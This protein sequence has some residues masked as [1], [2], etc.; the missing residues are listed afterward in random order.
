MQQHF[1][2]VAATPPAVRHV[3]EPH[4]NHSMAVELLKFITDAAAIASLAGCLYLIASMRVLQRFMRIA[5]GQRR[6]SNAPQPV[7]V[8]RPL[9]GADP[10]LYENLLSSC[11]Q[12][13]VSAELICGVQR[14]D[15][16][17]I[18]VVER[19]RADRPDHNVSLIVDPTPHGR[20]RKVAN[21]INMLPAARHG[22]LVIMDSD[23]RAPPDFMSRALGVLAE[24]G[25][26]LV[27]ALYRGRPAD[28]GF[29]SA[30]AA[31][32]INHG[33]LP[34]AL[35]GERLKPGI[36]CYGAGIAMERETL[37]AIGGFAAVS[38][39]LADDYALGE[40]VR[41]LGKRLMVAPLL[42]DNWLVEGSVA[43]LFRHELRWLLT[44]RSVAPSGHAGLLLTHPVALALI[45]AVVGAPSPIS[46][47]GLPVAL[48]V[49]FG[50]VRAVDHAL[51]LERTPLWRVPVR[52]LISFAVYVASFFAKTVAW[53]D[54]Q[55][56]VSRQGRLI[57][58]GDRA[59]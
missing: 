48:L 33:F 16:P 11:D 18:G 45:A 13:G 21:L 38:D 55:F 36:G 34:Q 35:L 44:I 56:E 40:G 32:Y 42:L 20:N 1:Q 25:A 30:L 59:R 9:H 49:R 19:L 12:S 39:A 41:K 31:Q 17:A 24:P 46:L 29:W 26:G 54:H 6:A 22:P 8:L 7:S 57:G 23:M 5:H 58:G 52:D 43:D 47:L 14:A 3:L 53:R 51:G 10:G 50:M 27:S 15:D 37:E 28:A 4:V 2:C